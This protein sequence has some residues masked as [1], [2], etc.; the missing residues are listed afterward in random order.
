VCGSLR[1]SFLISCEKD[2]NGT[3]R[4]KGERG[5]FGSASQCRL[6]L[7]SESLWLYLVFGKRIPSPFLVHISHQVLLILFF[8]FP[9]IK[10]GEEDGRRRRTHFVCVLPSGGIHVPTLFP[11]Q[12]ID[13]CNV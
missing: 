11:A 10:T 8:S 12:V 4:S 6:G 13:L 5:P 7:G 1:K 3:V 2:K 9:G